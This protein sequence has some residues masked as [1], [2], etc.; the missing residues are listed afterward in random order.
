[1]FGFV[2]VGLLVGLVDFAAGRRLWAG[3][4]RGF[5]LWFLPGL[6]LLQV[7]GS[8]VEATSS[9]AAALLAALLVN[10]LLKSKPDAPL[11]Q[12]RSILLPRRV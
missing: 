6:S 12:R 5:M 8:V 9:A 11:H 4:V 2:L 3:D 10:R 7:G 1:M